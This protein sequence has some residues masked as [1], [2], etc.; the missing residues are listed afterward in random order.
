MPLQGLA[1]SYKDSSEHTAAYPRLTIFFVLYPWFAPW[2]YTMG[3]NPNAP[4]GLS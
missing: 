1:N 3:Y 4:P 2:A